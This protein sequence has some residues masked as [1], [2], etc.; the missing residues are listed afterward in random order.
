[1]QRSE[2]LIEKNRRKYLLNIKPTA[3]KI[4]SYIKTHKQNE[5][6]RP[7]TDNTQ[8]PSYKTAKFINNKIKTYINLPNAY[9]TTN[10]REIAQEL[11]KLHVTEKYRIITLEIKDLYVNL[12]KQGIIHP[13]IFWLDKNNTGKKSQRTNY[14][15][16]KNNNR[17]ELFSI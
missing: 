12:P 16:P 15:I 6:I 4:N 7:V 8:A 10:S 1:M 5:P 17:T 2:D 14:K 11:H 3:P 9:I 13:T